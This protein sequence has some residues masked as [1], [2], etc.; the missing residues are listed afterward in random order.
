MLDLD[1]QIEAF[2]KTNWY[3]SGVVTSYDIES[4][5]IISVGALLRGCST[6]YFVFRGCNHQEIAKALLVEYI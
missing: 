3:S 5:T 1:I 4:L 6:Q 2:L